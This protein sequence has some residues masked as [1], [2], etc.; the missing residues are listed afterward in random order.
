MLPTKSV[1]QQLGILLAA[2]TTTLAPVAANKVALVM[3]PFVPSENLV[4]ADLTLA[5]F[6]GSTPIAGVAGAQLVGTDPA[7]LQE[8]ITNK[9]P[10]GGW[11]WITTAL[12]HLPETIYGYALI[13]NA[14]AT[15]IATATLPQPVTLSEIGDF[16][17]LGS[18][19]LTFVLQPIS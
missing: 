17:D 3:A 2:D 8:V 7:T 12:T 18:L 11:R 4:L 5:D 1:R 16:I 15:L 19:E 10:A 13:D 9:A 14:G 6:T